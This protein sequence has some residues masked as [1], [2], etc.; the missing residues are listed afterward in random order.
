MAKAESVNIDQYL[1]GLKFP[2]QRE[3]L[4]NH[5]RKQGADEQTCRQLN[6]LPNLHYRTINEVNR[7]WQQSWDDNKASRN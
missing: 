7:D 6:Q 2:V 3:E 1:Q 4:V 5:A